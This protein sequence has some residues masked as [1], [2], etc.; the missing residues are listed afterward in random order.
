MVGC[1]LGDGGDAEQ[2][3][4]ADDLGTQNVDRA[5][6]A[7]TAA[8]HES[9]KVGAANEREVR[10]HGEHCH[11]VRAGHDARVQDDLRVVAE[12]PAYG[13]E[14]VE[15]DGGAVKLPA[16]VVTQRN[17]RPARLGNMKRLLWLPALALVA[18]CGSALPEEDPAAVGTAD[19]V[20]TSGDTVEVAFVPDAG[21]EYFDGT[22]FVLGPEVPVGGAVDDAALI[23]SGDRL[24]VWTNACAESF[25]VQCIVTAVEVLD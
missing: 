21:Y 12:V 9:V 14:Q 22:T 4:G 24:H 2:L 3:H 16:T 8:G 13:R 6:H 23:S 19:A 17:L 11:D 1:E 7:L 10:S 20:V 25:P 15:G 5:V 18:G